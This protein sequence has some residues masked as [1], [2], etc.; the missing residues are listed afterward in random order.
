MAEIES[1][2]THIEAFGHNLKVNQWWCDR[3]WRIP[4]AFR[5]RWPRVTRQILSMH[6]QKMQDRVAWVRERNGQYT[7]S[8]AYDSIRYRGEIVNWNNSIW[9]S[10]GT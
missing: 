9:L 10:K 5:R 4:T 3:V 1:L 2:N 7:T 6:L 8:S